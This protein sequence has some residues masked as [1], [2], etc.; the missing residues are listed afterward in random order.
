[1]KFDNDDAFKLASKYMD[2]NV[3]HMSEI[4]YFVKFLEAYL[5]FDEWLSSEEPIEAA[6]G[7]KKTAKF[8]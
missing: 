8:V 7:A 2:H 5:K 6:K 4:N 3:E 1:M